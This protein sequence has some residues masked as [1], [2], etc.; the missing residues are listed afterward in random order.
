MDKV[1]TLSI[2]TAGACE[3]IRHGSIRVIVRGCP[4]CLEMELAAA[5]P[6]DQLWLVPNAGHTGAAAAE[7]EEFRRRV[8]TYF[9]EH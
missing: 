8:L 4:A 9:A 7:P 3:N 6:R 2:V 5:N 1:L